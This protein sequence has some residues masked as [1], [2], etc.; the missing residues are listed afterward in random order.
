MRRNDPK[1]TFSRANLGGADLEGVILRFANLE[2][3]TLVGANLEGA[4]LI[5]AT[6][7]DGTK[8]SPDTDLT[9][10]TDP[11]DDETENY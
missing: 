7:P 8:Y 5:G 1:V 3:A 10:F 6:M 4:K 9:K 2:G 11:P